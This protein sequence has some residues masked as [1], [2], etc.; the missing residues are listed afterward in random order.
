MNSRS[1][2][3]QSGKCRGPIP[4]AP[5]GR[6]AF[7]QAGLAGFATLS[8]P[9]ILRLQALAADNAKSPSDQKA[10]IMVWQP[11]GLSHLDSYDPKPDSGSEYRGPFNLI[12]TKV[13]GLQFTELMPRQAAIADK[14]VVLRSMRQTA[15]GH[16]AGSMQLLSGDPDTRDKPK[17]KYPDWMAVSNY[18][19]SQRGPRENPLPAYVGINP[20]LEYNGPAYLG[21]SYSPFVVSG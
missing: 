15:G 16:P 7:L 12:D 8:L 19:I 17:P 10:V 2:Q 3:N 21:D 14:L 9:N 20:P 5:S 18:L 1:S 13:P 11:G 4:F 6:R